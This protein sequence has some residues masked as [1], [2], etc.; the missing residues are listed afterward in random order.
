MLSGL[1]VYMEASVT[2]QVGS[3]GAVMGPHAANF[4]V[5][6]PPIPGQ[7]VA[8]ELLHLISDAGHAGGGAMLSP[9]PR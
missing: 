5:L 2:R 7:M 1:A 9:C 3:V 4:A 6:S 8:F